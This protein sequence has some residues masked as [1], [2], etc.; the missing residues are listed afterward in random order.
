MITNNA[1]DVLVYTWSRDQSIGI[2]FE[3]CLEVAA[4]QG[5]RSAMLTAPAT[6]LRLS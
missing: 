2:R 5:V 3:D 1:K 4:G 6:R